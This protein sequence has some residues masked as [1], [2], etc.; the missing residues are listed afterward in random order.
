[1]NINSRRKTDKNKA[2]VD[3]NVNALEAKRRIN[4]WSIRF[5]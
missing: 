5:R 1:M 3:N 2:T 4:K